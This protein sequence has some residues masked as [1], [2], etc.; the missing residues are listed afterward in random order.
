MQH[1]LHIFLG[2]ELL[3][4]AEAVNQHLTQHCDGEGRQFS[5][6]ASLCEEDGITSIRLLDKPSDKLAISN[7]TEGIGYFRN[8]H[9]KIAVADGT[10]EVSSYLYVCIYVQAYND[11]IQEAANT[12]IK[13]INKSEKHYIV[14][15]F[16]IAEDLAELF[17]ISSAEKSSLVYKIP[18]LHKNVIDF[19]SHVIALS[20][21]DVIRHFIILQ[22]CN[23]SGLGLDLDKS[24]LIRIIGEYARLSTTNFNDLFPA[25]SINNP[26]VLGLG[27]SAYWFNP[28]FFQSYIFSRCFVNILKREN[29]DQHKKEHPNQLLDIAG[30]YINMYPKLQSNTDDLSD[31]TSIAVDKFNKKLDE[32]NNSIINI[33]NR[34]DLSLPEKRAVFAILL[35]ADDELLDDSVLLNLLPTID[36]CISGAANLFISENNEMIE[37][38]TSEISQP[39][40]DGKVYL[41]LEELRKKRTA[42]RQSQ[43]FIRKSEKRL[44]EIE[45]EIRITHESKKRLTEGGFKY[46]DTTFRLQHDVVE[47]PLD[48][49]YQPRVHATQSIDLRNGFSEIR[50]QKGL[51]ACTAFSMASIFEYIINQGDSS[52]KTHLSPRFLYYNVCKKNID[53]T[54]I[55]KGSSFF[56][57]IKSLGESGICTESLCV[58]DED[59]NLSPTNEAQSDAKTRLVTK[60][61]NVEITHEALTSALTEGFPIGISLKI[62]DSFGK[63]HKG[64]VF[65]PTEKELG[66]TDYG[67]HAMVICG[68]SEKEK[69]Y[70]V[71]NSWG[72]GFG[73]NGYCF[74]PFS[75][76]EDTTLCRQACIVTGVNCGEIGITSI[77][78]P[79]FNLSDKDIEY[80]VLRV[81]ID[82]E[83]INQDKL[84]E[85]YDEC[86]KNYMLLLTDLSN[87]GKRDK[88]MDHALRNIPKERTESEEI[89]VTKEHETNKKYY[90]ILSLSVVV[91]TLILLFTA[92]AKDLKTISGVLAIIG[93]LAFVIVRLFMPSQKLCKEFKTLEKT[94]D[95][96]DYV[97]L[98]R[99]FLFAGCL[100]DKFQELRN[101]IANRHKH[102]FSYVFNLETWLHEEEVNLVNFDEGLKKPFYSL[103]SDL[104]ADLYLQSHFDEYTNDFWLYNRF[105][106]YGLSDN[107]IV[108]FKDKLIKDI[109]ERVSIISSS[110]SMSRY[111]LN[112]RNFPYLIE[113]DHQTLFSTIQN[114]SIPFVQ[115]TA[116]KPRQATSHILF[117]DVGS[118]F[119]DWTNLLAEQYAKQ[120]LHV[121]DLN[122]TKITYIQMQELKLNE[123]LYVT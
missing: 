37:D 8:L 110:F 33:V 75:Y 83:R 99:K 44:K 60:A 63:G 35:G 20:K 74:I 69:V 76:I 68:F 47:L 55:D 39:Q 24:T 85:E 32:A 92:S 10:K 86:Y 28:K 15:V 34:T 23:L 54:P 100:I 58:Y 46:G 19:S 98:E 102:L 109:K 50:N 103:F 112:M 26:E 12:I 30:E 41:P 42:I 114:M 116:G 56:D 36:D 21:Q 52:N 40:H 62:F 107:T 81:K 90:S 1:S 66:G 65:R 104:Q 51:G 16:G 11:A 121:R 79:D 38:G 82:E 2:D 94:F 6:V 113:I 4:V 67:Y 71:R 78:K 80:A 22:G 9:P 105:S 73:D 84:K 61:M 91:I 5:H 93:A 17:C 106:D 14:D 119:D 3:T 101:K 108:E 122:K 96:P 111:I 48:E 118:A 29:V 27:I 87:K 45:Q 88:I 77:E 97:S 95:N 120:P 64:F 72:L 53:G 89:E 7:D 18:S 117:C 123:T 43:S 59:F 115:T 25:S 70:I 13:W 49:T 31:D 57:N